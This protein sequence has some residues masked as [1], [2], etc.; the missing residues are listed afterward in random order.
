MKKK[1]IYT[2]M[3]TVAILLAS[4]QKLVTV[5]P[6]NSLTPDQTL[7]DVNGYLSLLTGAYANLEG[8]NYWGRDL[9]IEG[10]A[11]ADNIVTNNSQGAGRY[12]TANTNASGATFSI[13]TNSYFYINQLNTIIAGINTL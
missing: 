1:L 3:T 11:L 12:I 6:Q 10:D 5:N 7:V 2:C 9:I 8:Y 4:C 13:W